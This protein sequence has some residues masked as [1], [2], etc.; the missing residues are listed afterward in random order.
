[1]QLG[2]SIVLCT[3]N[4]TPR[5]EPT[6]RHLANLQLPASYAAELIFVD[7]A[8][9]DNT[10]EFVRA[11]WQALGAPF[12]LN[13]L[14]EPRSGK[15]Y[16]VEKGYD[17]A[18][19]SYILTVDDDNWLAPD[20]LTKAIELFVQHPDVRILQG[21]SE[22]EFEGT[23]PAWLADAR[24]AKQLVIGGPFEEDGYFPD[25]YFYV[26]GAGLIICA[27]DWQALRGKGLSFL[28]SKMPGKA[29]GEDSELGLGLTLL[30]S[31]AYY[32][33]ALQFKHFMPTGR[34]VWD[35]L[36]NNFEVLGYVSYY[37][38]LYSLVVEAH[39]NKRRITPDMV[40][41]KMLNLSRHHARLLTPK[42]HLAYWFKPMEQYYQLM[43]V[44]F[45]SRIKWYRQLSKTAMADVQTIQKWLLP[46]LDANQGK[47]RWP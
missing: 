44:E 15:G 18:H 20:Y 11:Q 27:E 43:L 47:F 10:A 16:A 4:G 2:F 36:K 22:A 38:M 12:S 31:K 32:S 24:I 46:L 23:P 41:S 7:N 40:R 1:M 6:L 39:R 5:L 35:K 30:N 42:Q 17:A 13:L 37:M 25:N 8:S 19:L 33:T 3:F 28:T 26:W 34:L 45:Y 21:I 14:T 29:A 9:T